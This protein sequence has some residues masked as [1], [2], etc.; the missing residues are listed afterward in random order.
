MDAP[1]ALDEQRDEYLCFLRVERGLAAHTLEAYSRDI[2]Q[3][4]DHVRARGCDDFSSVGADEL[5]GWV[6]GLAEAGL[7]RTSQ[8]RMLVA[9]RGLYRFLVERYGWADNPCEHV[10]LPK[11]GRPLPSTVDYDA[12]VRL[13]HAESLRDRALIALWYGAGLRVSEA[14]LLTMDALHVDAGLIVVRGKGRKERVVPVGTSA[15]DIVVAYIRDDRPARLKGRTSDFLFP[16]R[17]K[18]GALTRQ[19]AFC[20]LRRLAASAGLPADISPHTLRHAFATHLVQG[21]ADLRAIQAMLGHS[22]LRT[23]E[24]YTHIDDRHVRRV[25]DRTHPRA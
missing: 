23:T 21:G 3:F 2:G 22:D 9:V 12:V 1:S 7:A 8:K 15:L 13:L 24:I 5:S 18:T 19:A 4:I 25:Y 6:R 16:G 11:L 17:G 10:D 14:V 20:V